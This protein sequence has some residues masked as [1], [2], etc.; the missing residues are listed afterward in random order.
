MVYITGFST[1]TGSETLTNKTLTAPIISSILNTGTLTLPTSTDTLVGRATTDTLTNKSL[2]TVSNTVVGNT[3][4]G[5]VAISITMGTLNSDFDNG[6][7]VD[8][9]TLSTGD[10]V[11]LTAQSTASENGPWIVAS[12]GS[13]SRPDWF[14]GTINASGML[15]ASSGGTNYSGSVFFCSTASNIIVDTDSNEWTQTTAVASVTGGD[16]I[17][18]S[19][20]TVSADLK[21]NGGLVIESGEIA[22]DLGASSITNGPS[23]AIVGTTDSQTLTNKTLTTPVISQISNSGTITLPSTTDTLIGRATTDTLTNKTMTSAVLTT[24]K[25]NDSASNHQYIMAAGGDLADNRTITFP[26]LAADATVEMLSLASVQTA[27]FNAS[28]WTIYPC[29]TDT[30]S[31]PITVTLPKLS[32]TN[33]GTKIVVADFGGNASTYKITLSPNASDMVGSKTTAGYSDDING[34]Y[35]TITLVGVYNGGTN[36]RWLYL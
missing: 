10:Y 27:T 5:V 2:N 12:S 30:N 13:P 36:P 32:E 17:E 29:D 9:V 20:S 22:V 25:F 1:L 16:G 35:N 8:G 21:A 6:K 28:E 3:L 24:P 18:V 33:E 26:L 34:N 19:G 23:G 15:I 11:L 14:T 7:T 31:Q 4:R